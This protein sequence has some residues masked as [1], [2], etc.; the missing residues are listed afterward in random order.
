MVVVITR[1]NRRIGPKT[2][3]FHPKIRVVLRLTVPTGGHMSNYEFIRSFLEAKNSGISGVEALVQVAYDQGLITKQEMLPLIQH[4]TEFGGELPTDI[5]VPED[6]FER[7]VWLTRWNDWVE[8]IV[9]KLMHNAVIFSM[10]DKDEE[11]VTRDQLIHHFPISLDELSLECHVESLMKD[12]TG[13]ER[14]VTMHVNVLN[15]RSLF[16]MQCILSLPQKDIRKLL[17]QHRRITIVLQHS[18]NGKFTKLK[19]LMQPYGLELTLS[20]MS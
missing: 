13:H 17:K 9:S 6:K 19:K 12:K 20:R 10:I 1:L 7:V 14:K 8:C 2:L 5:E 16:A 3:I 4:L 11:G 15:R 18:G